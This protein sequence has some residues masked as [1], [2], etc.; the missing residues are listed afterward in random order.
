MKRSVQCGPSPAVDRLR[1]RVRTLHKSS[2]GAL[3]FFTSPDT[4]PTKSASFNDT[5][6]SP[7]HIENFD[8][9]LC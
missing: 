5:A 8:V 7:A 4:V 6:A 2:A 3:L 1:T 9:Q